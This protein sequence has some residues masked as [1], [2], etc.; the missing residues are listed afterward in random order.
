MTVAA[1]DAF[2]AGAEADGRPGRRLAAL[3]GI[4]TLAV[5]LVVLFHLGV[6]GMAGGFLGVDVFFV[7]SGFLITTLLLRDIVSHGRI[8]LTRFW[9]R[10]MSRLMPAV[11]LL[12]LV[13]ALWAALIA[14]AF[15]LPGIGADLL[16]CILYVGNWH[17]IGT[18]SYFADDG[19]ISPLLHLWSL[20]VEEQFY[21]LWPLLMAA[22]GAL[23]ASPG[24][25]QHAHRDLLGARRRSTTAV[26]ISGGV[27]AA[28]SIVLMAHT[29]LSAGADRAYMG[30]DTKVFEPLLGAV[31]AAATFRP[32]VAAFV[33]RN[34]QLL[35]SG[36]T[37]AV[38]VAVA[39][40]GD[41]SGPRAAYFNGGAVALCLA[42][43][44]L[45]AGAIQADPDVGLAR[46]FA[47][48]A[49]AYLGRI[50]YGLYLWHWPWA[51]WLLTPGTFEPA[52]AALVAALTLTT[53]AASYHWLEL[54]LRSGKLRLVPSARI[55][56][57]GFGAM[58]VA[59]F[60]PFLL[61]GTPLYAGVKASTGTQRVLLIGD[62][63]PH[64]L[65]AAFAEAGEKRGVVID[66][67]A[68][69][70]CSAM[71]ILTIN[72]DGSVY[73]PP[74]P[75]LPGTSGPVCAPVA[76]EQS[77]AVASVRP[78]TVLWWSRYE[79]ADRLSDQGT[80]LRAND[81]GFWDAQREALERTVDRV[82]AGGAELVIVEPEPPGD[83]VG[84]GCLPQHDCLPFLI[85]LRD[86]DDVRRQWIQVLR[87]EAT[88][89]PRVHLISVSDV[90]C[91][92]AA[93][94]CDD[95][96]P[97]NTGSGFPAPTGEPARADGSHFV[98][99]ASGEVA[100]I[101]LGRALQVQR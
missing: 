37:A 9:A 100:D 93:S 58:A 4:R 87:Q 16:W 70:G 25:G 22:V 68:H 15:R 33:A 56:K 36:G 7:L 64:Q 24:Q 41:G 28:A 18:N 29:Y 48:P 75:R 73:N 89:D 3:D 74:T 95:R 23:L 1:P 86:E 96:L 63:V 13:V 26:M 19:T 12:F 55:L 45:V 21:L 72:G 43:V 60:L 98:L 99:E 42:V 79:Y 38:L 10:R 30:T 80:P 62:S 40:L 76:E 101:V 78:T 53:A 65:T 83:Q 77:E 11:L 59:C 5:G 20:G 51:A 88:R 35:L 49:M 84:Q 54:P 32:A 44:A 50:S 31:A 2:L 57:V 8:D 17:F 6:P 94:P 47:H 67:G 92:N 27:V 34:A 71:G 14:P 46:V 81:P 91:R 61:G 52:R 66:D 69:G 97:L 85:R 90:F 82:T 39:T